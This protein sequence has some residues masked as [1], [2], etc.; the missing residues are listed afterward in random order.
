MT[1]RV[2]QLIVVGMVALG[3]AAAS[4]AQPGGARKKGKRDA[5]AEPQPMLYGRL[6]VRAVPMDKK[7]IAAVLKRLPEKMREQMQKGRDALKPGLIVD[8]ITTGGPAHQAGLRKGD[9]ITGI[10]GR[11]Y[12]NDVTGLSAAV[13]KL[14]ASEHVEIMFVRRGES[15][16]CTVVAADDEFVKRFKNASTGEGG[17]TLEPKRVFT[18]FEKD[19][20][21]YVPA[22]WKSTRTGKGTTARWEVVEDKKAYSGSRIV[23]VRE[24][25]NAGDTWNV[26]LFNEAAYTDIYMDVRVRLTAGPDDPCAGFVWGAVDRKNYYLCSVS[27]RDKKMALYKMENGKAS[28][29]KEAEVKIAPG[30]WHMLYVE[31]I[32]DRMICRF[33]NDLKID[34]RDT[35]FPEGRIGFCTKA[36]T[37][38]AFDKL[39]VTAP[40]IGKLR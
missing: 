40:V 28:L 35:T 38:A 16:Q 29:V 7:T 3:V 12:E 25:A 31:K 2:G 39:S 23:A 1:R 30:R 15:R 33:D 37:V 8:T 11:A 18:D 5:G 26:C 19:E 17:K 24:P 27:V 10:G 13:E 14:D 22:G 4:V 20:V 34:V 32:R 21:G 6:G 9:I 36:D